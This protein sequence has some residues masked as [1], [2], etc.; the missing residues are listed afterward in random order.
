MSFKEQLNEKRVT[1]RKYRQ[2]IYVWQR[3]FKYIICE[4]QRRSHEYFKITAPP[5][6]IFLNPKNI[7]SEDSA[8]F[9]FK[10]YPGFI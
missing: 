2:T 8:H 3:T 4:F 5:Q 10:L 6:M 7:G 9:F 1:R